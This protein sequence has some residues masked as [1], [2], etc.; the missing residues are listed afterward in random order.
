VTF[1]RP[2]PP[3]WRV[4]T[5]TDAQRRDLLRLV[6]EDPL[7]NAVIASRLA[8]FRSIEPSRFGGALIGVRTTRLVGAT[9]YGGNLLPIGGEPDSWHAIARHLAGQSRVC[10]SIVGRTS[11][12]EAMWPHLEPSWG[13]ARAIRDT[14]PLLAL[15][16]DAAPRKADRRVRTMRP[17]D[18]DRYL[19]AA[20]AMF[21]EEL[22]VSPFSGQAG[23][24]YRARVESLLANGRA[25]GI[26]DEHGRMAFKADI[27]AVSADTAQIQGVWVRPDLRG[28]GLGTAALARVMQHALRMAPT[29]SLYVND[30]NTPAR[31]V[32][33]KLGM[34]QV[35]SLSTVLF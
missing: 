29:A 9:F 1:L 34:R 4:G 28:R 31:R 17:A 22:G 2:A 20:A 11:A 33:A 26:V 5:L 15:T 32:Y 8:T 24:T 13:P 21:T 27:G 35:A 6:A 14:Q 12:V 25:F 16:R 23:G 19:P 10:T 3:A 7:V 18:I 30:F